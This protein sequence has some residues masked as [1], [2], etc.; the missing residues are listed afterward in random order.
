MFASDDGKDVFKINNG[1]QHGNWLDFFH[2]IG[3]YNRYFPEAKYELIGFTK[4]DYLLAIKPLSDYI[5]EITFEPDEVRF[6]NVK[7]YLEFG[8]FNEL[9]D[10]NCFN[11]VSL[12]LDSI[13]WQNG[14]DFSPET[15]YLKST[16]LAEHLA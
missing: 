13:K 14:Q 1:I 11:S 6:F 2:R 9:K 12:F 15:L 16:H 10:Q 7:P 4:R 5:L 3:A 8:I